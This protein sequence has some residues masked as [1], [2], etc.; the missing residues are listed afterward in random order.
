[1]TDGAGL[2]DRELRTWRTFLGVA[3]VLNQQVEQQLK[4]TAGLS[5]PQYEVLARLSNA[6]DGELRMTELAGIALTSKSGLSYQVAQLEKA[7]LVQRRPCATDERGIVAVLTEAGWAKLRES[8]PNHLAL[9]RSAFVESLSAN[10]FAALTAA[11]DA[12]GT[13]LGLTGETVTALRVQS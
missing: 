1:M 5:H 8:A 12:L 2:S 4:D 7:G 13:H 10:E 3:T 6:P 9:V 11:V